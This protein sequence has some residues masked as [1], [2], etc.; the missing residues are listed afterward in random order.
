MAHYR[1]YPL[2]SRGG[3]VGRTDAE[4]TS[5]QEA[6][7]LAQRMLDGHGQAEV[8]EGPRCVG[9]VSAHS[10]AE[11]EALGRLPEAG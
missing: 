7:E 2:N 1:I 5:D 10:V 9:R 8:W 6:R 3:F 11:I 4:C